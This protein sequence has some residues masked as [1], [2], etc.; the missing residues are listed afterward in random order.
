MTP[1]TEWLSKELHDYVVAHSTPTD[2]IMARLADETDRNLPEQSGMR[3]GPEQALLMTMLTR[4]LHVRTAVEVGTF[5]G[6]S[7]LAI[8]RGL[9]PGGRLSCFDVS[10]EYT[11][12]ARR[13]WAE[14]GVDDRIELTIG[15]AA[16][17]LR[18]LPPDPVVDLSFIDADKEGYVA[19]W[20]ELVPRTRP[21][22]VLLVDNTL[23]HGRVLQ[24]NPE[25]TAAAGIKAFNDHAL[26]DPRV[27]LVLLPLGDG[28]TVARKLE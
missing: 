12:I 16:E 27:E 26:A 2:E 23:S 22:G 13:Y 15:P 28:L 25:S 14:A 20:E 6:Y 1:R 17:T 10:E 24:E 5:T 21:G 9:A 4:L 3:S 8:S 19:Y 18:K 7:A 11:G